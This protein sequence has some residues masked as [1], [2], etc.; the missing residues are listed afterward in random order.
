MQPQIFAPSHCSGRR[1]SYS[2]ESLGTW[3]MSPM[4][5][6]VLEPPLL[7]NHAH[8]HSETNLT[9]NL[10]TVT[11]DTLTCPTNA[12]TDKKSIRKIPVVKCSAIH[13]FCW[14]KKY[15]KKR[16]LPLT[17]HTLRSGQIIPRTPRILKPTW[18]FGCLGLATSWFHPR[19]PYLK[20]SP[21]EN[22]FYAKIL[23]LPRI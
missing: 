13:Q 18:L 1:A 4:E 5:S 3:E 19:S 12:A 2:R 20:A 16:T 22:S 10:N 14:R 23:I 15:H 9:Q 11:Y 6:S 8:A 17:V 21:P 7:R